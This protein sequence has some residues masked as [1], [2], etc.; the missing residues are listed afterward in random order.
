MPLRNIGICDK[1]T[2]R[3]HPEEKFK[4][5]SIFKG[6][7]PLIFGALHVPFKITGLNFLLSVAFVLNRA[8]KERL[9]LQYPLP[10]PLPYTSFCFQLI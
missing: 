10:L 5:F 9:S 6:L 8:A 3:H 1:I 2:R 7:S 4:L